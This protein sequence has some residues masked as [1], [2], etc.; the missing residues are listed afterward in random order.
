MSNLALGSVN[1]AKAMYSEDARSTGEKT[2]KVRKG[3]DVATLEGR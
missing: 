2:R 3:E 1:T